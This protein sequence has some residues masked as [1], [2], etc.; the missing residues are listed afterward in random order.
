MNIRLFVIKVFVQAF[1]MKFFLETEL[2]EIKR[3]LERRP[4]SDLGN[5]ELFTLV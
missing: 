1:R 3:R 4:A 5:L 2:H